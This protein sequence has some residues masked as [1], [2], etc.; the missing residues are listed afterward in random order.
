MGPGSRVQ[1]KLPLQVPLFPEPI[2][3]GTSKGEVSPCGPGGTAIIRVAWDDGRMTE[4]YWFHLIVLSEPIFWQPLEG[5][6]R[7]YPAYY[8]SVEQLHRAGL[9]SRCPD[10]KGCM[11]AYEEDQRRRRGRA[12]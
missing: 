12:A 10:P 8:T 6:F 1:I 11:A 4:E 9:H 5:H 2:V 7:P 3:L